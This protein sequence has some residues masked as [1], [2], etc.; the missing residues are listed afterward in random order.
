LQ[1]SEE[2]ATEFLHLFIVA[3]Y[4]TPLLGAFISDS[5][6]GKYRTILY[7]SLIYCL[8]N[9]AMAASALPSQENHS[10]SLTLLGLGLIALGTGGIKPCVSAFGGDQIELSYPP[11]PA[12]NTLL[13]RFFSAFY[14]SIN[15]GAVLSTLIT[16]LIR[17]YVNYAWAFAIPA[18]LMMLSLVLFY[19]GSGGYKHQPPGGNVVAHVAGVIWTAV[20][21]SGQKSPEYT[22]LPESEP[23]AQRQKATRPPM[24]RAPESKPIGIGARARF[25]NFIGGNSLR[26]ASIFLRGT[27]PESR[28]EHLTGQALLSGA[29]SGPESGASARGG[30]NFPVPRPP[31]RRNLSEIGAQ[32]QAAPETQSTPGSAAAVMAKPHW[33]DRAKAVH[34]ERD[35]EDVKVLLRVLLLFVPAPLFWSLFDQQSSRWVFQARKL[36][37]RLPFGLVIE[38]DQM[39]V[40][41]ISSLQGFCF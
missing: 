29:E 3:C 30:S 24:V 1:Q 32:T 16:P 18:W 10:A 12:R 27:P 11:S 22:A 17:S 20:T 28:P 40:R 21:S 19:L 23:Q 14:F 34:G 9:W 36:D 5:Y 37:G 15:A 39:Q 33:L 41:A 25:S 38:P 8:G 6:I 7:L 26:T 35:V 4:M 2:Q 31:S 13:R